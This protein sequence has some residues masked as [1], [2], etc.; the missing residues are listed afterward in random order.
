MSRRPSATLRPTRPSRTLLAG[1]VL[2][3][4][5]LALIVT[6]PYAVGLAATAAP[7]PAVAAI[8]TPAVAPAGTPACKEWQTVTQVPIGPAP[9]AKPGATTMPKAPTRSVCRNAPPKPFPAP[10]WDPETVVG[11]SELAASGVIVAGGI[12]PPPEVEDVSYVIA[13]MDSGDILAA[14]SPH[15]WLRPASTLKALTALALLPVVKPDQVVIATKEHV[16]ANGTRVGMI[17]GNPYPARSLFEAMLMLSANDATYGLTAAVG[18]YDRALELMN[19][20]AREI[21]AYDTVAVDP[22]GLDEDGQHTS[23]YDLALIGRDAMQREDFRA[24]VAK[25]QTTFPGGTEKTT[26]KVYPAFQIPNINDLLGRYPGAIG[27]KPGR[28]NRAQHTFIGAATRGGHTLIVSQMGSTNGSWKPTAALLDWGFANLGKVSPV[29]RLVDPG[30]ATPPTEATAAS[31][32]PTVASSTPAPTGATGTPA[33]PVAAS[34]WSG[35]RTAF[36]QSWPV[37]GLLAGLLLGLLVLLLLGVRRLV[38]GAR[39]GSRADSTSR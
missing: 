30:V 6:T 28:T 36:A 7:R 31:P 23:A 24:Y 26:G 29:G 33:P 13:D 37:S 17:A 38:R 32:G 8:A 22:S 15:S 10:A 11:G 3:A 4:L 25:R 21:G 39:A 16:T 5:A 12:S 35:V 2:W 18:G 9:A 14:K 1:C 19:A 20:K 34:S 27:V